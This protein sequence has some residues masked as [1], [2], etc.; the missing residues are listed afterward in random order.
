MN[1]PAS[2]G[3]FSNFSKWFR[4]A[5]ESPRASALA[6]KC[7]WSRMKFENYEPWARMPMRG[8]YRHNLD[9]TKGDFG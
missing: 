6:E 9:Y 7:Y 3:P 2:S 1:R 8:S 5:N 4:R